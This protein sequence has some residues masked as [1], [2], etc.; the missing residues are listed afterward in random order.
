MSQE[1]GELPGGNDITELSYEDSRA[2]L[3]AVVAA[4]EQG[5]TTLETSLA[6]WE[7][8]EALAQRCQAWLDGAR[9]R[10]AASVEQG[11]GASD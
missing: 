3:E 10:I 8:G 5:N 1:T 6:L 4:L 11:S 7:R 2:A 9:E